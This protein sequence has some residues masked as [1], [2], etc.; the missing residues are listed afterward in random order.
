MV[1]VNDKCIISVSFPLKKKTATVI[2][3]FCCCR[4]TIRSLILFILFFFRWCIWPLLFAP[5][6]ACASPP[7][8]IELNRMTLPVFRPQNDTH[9]QCCRFFL[10][11]FALLLYIILISVSFG[12]VSFCRPERTVT[13]NILEFFFYFLVIFHFIMRKHEEGTLSIF[14]LVRIMIYETN[15]FHYK[16]A[17]RT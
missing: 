6:F 5:K 1:N 4:Y 17:R 7:D 2:G 9:A 10:V 13:F 11:Y 12:R 16:V 14:C 15:I 3:W 8:R